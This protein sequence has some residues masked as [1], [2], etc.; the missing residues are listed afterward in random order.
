[1][2]FIARVH[3]CGWGIRVGV[4]VR[5]LIAHAHTCVCSSL[6]GFRV[7]VSVRINIF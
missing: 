6:A 5:V 1:M 3:A 7:R 4:R 2:V